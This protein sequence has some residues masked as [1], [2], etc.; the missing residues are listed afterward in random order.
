MASFIILLLLLLL[1]VVVEEGL[2]LLLLLLLLLR[3]GE[4]AR[5]MRIDLPF[6]LGLPPIRTVEM[7]VGARGEAGV[8]LAL[9]FRPVS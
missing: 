3:V 7:E 1:V 6:S 2:L 8:F 5:M 4:E 9:S